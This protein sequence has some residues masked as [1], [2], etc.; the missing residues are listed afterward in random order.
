MLTGIEFKLKRYAE[1][2]D[3]IMDADKIRNMDKSFFQ[4]N[5]FSPQAIAYCLPKIISYNDRALQM[6][7]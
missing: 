1:I 3:G 4:I 6:P 5:M 7:R 2:T